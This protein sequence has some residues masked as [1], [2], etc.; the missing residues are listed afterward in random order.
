MSIITYG[1]F[2]VSGIYIWHLQQL[3]IITG[4]IHIYIQT[5]LYAVYTISHD[6]NLQQ[7]AIL[8]Y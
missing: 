6:R 5:G 2:D 7:L 3:I 8:A 1:S 4:Y